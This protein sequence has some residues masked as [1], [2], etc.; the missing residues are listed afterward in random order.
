MGDQRPGRRADG[1]LGAPGEPAGFIAGLHQAMWVSGLALLG[2]AALAAW[3]LRP[4]G[5]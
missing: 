3:L 5:A 1:R 2:A 4:R